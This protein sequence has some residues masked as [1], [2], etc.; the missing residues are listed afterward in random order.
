MVVVTD[1]TT[2]VMCRQ[3]QAAAVV[4][5]QAAAVVA[6]AVIKTSKSRIKEFFRKFVKKGVFADNIYIDT[7]VVQDYLG[8]FRFRQDNLLKQLRNFEFRLERNEEM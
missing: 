8:W 3:C 7:I 6:V 4:V 5:C 2:A 1:T